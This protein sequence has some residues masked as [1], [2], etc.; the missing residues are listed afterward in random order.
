MKA[1]DA[2]TCHAASL[3]QTNKALGGEV[4]CNEIVVGCGGHM[5]TRKCVLKMLMSTEKVSDM[6]IT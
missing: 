5:G 1:R 6:K 2:M 3:R 4:E